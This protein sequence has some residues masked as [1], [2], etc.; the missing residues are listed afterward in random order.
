MLRSLNRVVGMLALPLLTV[1]ALACQSPTDPDDQIDYDDVIDVTGNPNPIGAGPSTDGRTYRVQRNEQP[2]EIRPYDWYAQFGIS[3]VFNQDA[4][5]D[6]VDVDFPVRLTQVQ[7]KVLQATS[8]VPTPPTGSDAEHSEFASLGSSGS[9]FSAVGNA[10]NMS[11]EI[12][13]DLPSLRK[14]GIARVT[15]SFQDDD[16]VAF[17]K[18]EDIPIAP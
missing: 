6:D 1:T 5:D 7:V 9:T 2:D 13:Y 4:L 11:F 18:V 16:G 17:Q 3:I 14:E 12:W 8:G 15:L 10:I